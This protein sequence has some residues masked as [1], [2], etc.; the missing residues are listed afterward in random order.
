MANEMK[1]LNVNAGNGS[2]SFSIMDQTARDIANEAKEVAESISVP[3]KLP[4]PQKL[5]F[6]GGATG[7]YDGSSAVTINIP[8]GGDGGSNVPITYVESLD[9]SNLKNLRDLDSGNYILYG[10]FTP[11]PGAPDSIT[12]DNCIAAAVHLNAGSHVMVCN[13]RNFKIECYEVLED[14]SAPDGFTYTKTSISML[15]VHTKLQSDGRS[16]KY[17]KEVELLA[18]NW[19]T[20]NDGKYYQHLDIAVVTPT[21]DLDMRLDDETIEILQD[22][23]LTFGVKNVNGVAVVTATGDKPTLD[24]TVQIT[25]EEVVWI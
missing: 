11:Y 5:T 2:F 16:P 18:A 15:D 22:K 3:A 17:I 1:K 14:E 25:I 19:E 8:T 12:I 23:V 4:N 21:S 9:D 20:E 10:Y 6:T 7:T 24:Y 13:P